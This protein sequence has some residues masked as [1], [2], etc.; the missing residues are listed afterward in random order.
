MNTL[1]ENGLQKDKLA[2]L[3][4]E[5]KNANIA[6][7]LSNGITH[8]TDIQNTIIQGTVFGSLICTSVVD[9]LAR[10]FYNNPNIVYQY[11]KEVAIPCLGMVDDVLCLNTCSN[12]AVV[13]NATVNSFMEQNKLKL[14]ATKCKQIHIG[15]QSMVCPELKIHEEIMKT[16]NKE[17]YLGDY[18]TNDAKLDTTIA[19]RVA[20][21]WS[22]TIPG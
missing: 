18:L 22:M 9:K 6:I 20:K 16:S 19:N 3:Y 17:K 15:K 14:S 4:E 11:K 2:L 21:A 8:I 12:M 10:M 13:S 7:K 1:Y 5:T